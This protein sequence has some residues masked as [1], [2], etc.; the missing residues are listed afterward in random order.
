MTANFYK[1]LKTCS[2]AV[3]FVI[4]TACASSPR[5]AGPA[6]GVKVGEGSSL[7]NMVPASQL[8]Q[9]ATKQYNS[10]K[11]KASQKNAL[12]PENHPQVI[13]LRAIAKK[14][15]PHAYAWN[16]D[17]QAWKW[18]INLFVSDEVNAFCMPGGK[19]A[20][21]TGILE[22]LKL[23]D[24]EVATVMGHEIAHALREHARD[25]LAKSQL[26]NLGANVLSQALGLGSLGSQAINQGVQLVG[27]SFSRSDEKDADLVGMDLAARAGYDPRAGISLWQKMGQL[28]KDR[29]AEWLSTHPS[30]DSRIYEI[31]RNLSDVLPL[32]AK[33]KNTT[34]DHLPDYKP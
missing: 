33:A 3:L 8:E 22:K 21:Y 27:L 23:N 26:G 5:H 2:A 16:P 4:L 28:S 19:I 6:D 7:K 9:S 25:R 15:L 11:Q 13:R 18:E 24:D 14:I 1:N 32:Y 20:F 34:V 12:A 17:S 10:M 31:Q 29:P 30:G